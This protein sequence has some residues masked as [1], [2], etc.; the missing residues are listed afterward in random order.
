MST[1]I[2]SSSSASSSSSEDSDSEIAASSIYMRK[3][4]LYRGKS[5]IK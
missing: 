4:D 2:I 5:L 1:D 3:L